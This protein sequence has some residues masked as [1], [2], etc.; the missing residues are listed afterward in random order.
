MQLVSA[1]NKNVS[2]ILLHPIIGMKMQK[3]IVQAICG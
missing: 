3:Q 2:N 1:E